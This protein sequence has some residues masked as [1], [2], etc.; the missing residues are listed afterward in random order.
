[1][2]DLNLGCGDHYAPGW[3]NVDLP[4][5]P[6]PHDVD[7]DLRGP[8][9]WSPGT[10][11]RLYLGHVLEHLT[12]VDAGDLLARLRPLMVPAGQVMVVGPDCVRAQAMV[13]AG[14]LDTHALDLVRHGGGRWVGDEHRWECEPGTI[15]SLLAGAGW[16][17]VTEVPI[18]DVPDVWPVVSR[19]GWQ[20]AVGAVA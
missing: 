5:T 15:R 17:Q 14:E 6:N 12:L 13:R 16:S 10:V 20:C 8:L 9:P 1:M 2:V 19:I 11:D 3:V 7:C 18:V 4:D